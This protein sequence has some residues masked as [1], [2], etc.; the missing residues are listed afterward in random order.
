MTQ[1]LAINLRYCL[2][3]P[4]KTCRRAAVCPPSGADPDS[5][6]RGGQ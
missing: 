5:K 4:H 1:Q 3:K 2:E 6:S